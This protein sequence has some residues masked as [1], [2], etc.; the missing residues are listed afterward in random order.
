MRSAAPEVIRCSTFGLD[1]T[2]QYP[3]FF[4]CAACKRYDDD[5]GAG[6]L[7]KKANPNGNRSIYRCEVDHASALHP[8]VLL[9]TKVYCPSRPLPQSLRGPSTKS[10]IIDL[11][12]L[13]EED[14]KPTVSGD[15]VTVDEQALVAQQLEEEE[16]LFVAQQLEEE[17]ALAGQQLEE[18]EAL[19]GQQ[20]EEEEALAE[21]QW[22]QMKQALRMAELRIE[23]LEKMVRNLKS[24]VVTLQAR[25]NNELEG[26]LTE[27]IESAVKRLSIRGK[28]IPESIVDA[29][30]RVFGGV[31]EE[32]LVDRVKTILRQTVYSPFNIARLMDLTGGIL[33]L[34]CIDLLRQLETKGKK[35]YQGSIIP[36]SS[37]IQEVF[38]RV[39]QIGVVRIPYEL[40]HL[41]SGECIRF[42]FQCMVICLMEAFKLV[43]VARE[44]QIEFIESI[45]GSNLDKGTN[46]TM[47]GLKIADPAAI[48]PLTK[49]LMLG[50]DTTQEENVQLANM[51]SRNNCFPLEI[52]CAPENEEMYT[53]HF[54]PMF[55]YLT[56]ISNDGIPDIGC[57]PIKLTCDCDM[58][59]AWKGLQRGGAAK[60]KTF[61][62]HCC[63]IRSSDLHHPMMGVAKCD[64]CRTKDTP[65]WKC[66]HQPIVTDEVLVE[67]KE[68]IAGMSEALEQLLEKVSDTKLT[69]EDP[70]EP[71]GSATRNPQSIHFLPE[72]RAERTSFS[73]LLNDELTLRAGNVT[74]GEERVGRL[75]ERRETLRVEVLR[76][77]HFRR[78]VQEVEACERPD[79]AVFLLMQCV[80]CILHMENRIGLKM[81]QMLLVSGLSA[82][83][84]KTLFVEHSGVGKR[85]DQMITSVSAVMNANILGSEMSKAHWNFPYDE[86]TK[87][88]KPLSLTNV[89]TRKAID[90]LEL[91]IEVVVP[92]DNLKLMWRR[93]IPKYR[94]A[95]QKLR[96]KN[97][98]TEED[99]LEFQGD[100][101]DWFQ[102]WVSLHG[103]DGMTNYIHLLASGHV[104]EYLSRHRNMYKHSQQGW[105]AF[106][107]LLKSF[108][109]RRTGRGGGRGA[110]RTKL[111]PIARW[112]QRRVLWLC[113][114]TEEEIAANTARHLQVEEE[115]SSSVPEAD[116]EV[117]DL[118]LAMAAPASVMI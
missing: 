21:Q 71:E 101:D 51:Q 11:D 75:S 25:V 43:R 106:N 81:L 109:F 72:T 22:V 65:G 19:A 29:V 14:E 8:T 7:S 68:A 95:M 104:S 18:E 60:V 112:L 42:N 54:K 114:L 31:A 49:T 20:L 46:H 32:E 117:S 2:Q 10:D 103:A 97:D 80:P 83:K 38:R 115:A 34:S 26:T 74:T 77:W 30:F 48:N 47:G 67:K 39:E 41:P 91:L 85:I 84:E 102:D 82:A 1:R 62:C 96:Q 94:K 61:P 66:Y 98:F 90:K 110:I 107:A 116:D 93:C 59:A 99:I 113:G 17:E 16:A 69:I 24:K 53:E 13:M 100:V 92:D 45:D 87:T 63:G 3:N 44:R 40:L 58:S 88:L 15:D 28:K 55:D 6:I 78:V 35:Y 12:L 57:M 27:S 5:L 73:K 50:G 4:F 108:Y 9:P 105:E 56:S 70:S 76:E 37:S 111:K 52:H 79:T 36:S 89:K 23:Q 64:K 86:S 118:L 33:N